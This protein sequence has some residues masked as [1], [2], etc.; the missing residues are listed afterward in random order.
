MAFLLTP[1]SLAQPPRRRSRQQLQSSS[2]TTTAMGNTKYHHPSAAA[3]VRELQEA[4][5]VA[6][7][8]GTWL[9]GTVQRLRAQVRRVF[10]C[11][12]VCTYVKMGMGCP[13]PL[14]LS[15]LLYY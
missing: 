6:R 12:Y 14:G 10:L 11:A 3:L 7:V 8:E 5:R 4:L 1:S 2:S 13:C 15:L 9:R